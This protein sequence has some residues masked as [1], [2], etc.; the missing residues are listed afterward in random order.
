[1][2]GDLNTLLAAID[3]S[4]KKKID[5]EILALNDTLDQMDIINIYR[6]FLPRTLDYPFFSSTHGTFSKIEHML[7]HKTSLDKFKKTEIIPSIFSDRSALK[8]DINCKKKA[9]SED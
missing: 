1:M 5:K 3:S 7:G 9:G 4:F 6:T 8:L 2:V